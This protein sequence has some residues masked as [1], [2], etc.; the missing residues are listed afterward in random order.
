MNLPTRVC[1]NKSSEYNALETVYEN[2]GDNT[3]AD[4]D[5]I[6]L[7][8]SI[9][10]RVDDILHKLNALETTTKSQPVVTYIVI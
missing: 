1:W 4:K 8:K 2:E 10:K 3:H 5:I 9:S 6:G 7:C